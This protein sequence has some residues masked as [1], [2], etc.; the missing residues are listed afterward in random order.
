MAHTS[1][2]V[3]IAALSACSD[4]QPPCFEVPGAPAPAVSKR[5]PLDDSEMQGCTLQGMS[6]GKEMQGRTLQGCEL[7]GAELRLSTLNGARARWR[8]AEVRI[9]DGTLASPGGA[10][11]VGQRLDVVGADGERFEVTLTRSELR[12]GVEHYALAVGGTASAPVTSSACSSPVRGT[13]AALTSRRR[14][15]SRIRA[16]AE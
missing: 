8:D 13:S 5:V 12:A 4:S 16:R 14:R 11:P 15:R 10:V 3:L 1:R 2:V 7:Q 9:V 6:V